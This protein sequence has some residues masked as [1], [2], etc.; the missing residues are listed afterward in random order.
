MN[1]CIH[2]MLY[3]SPAQCI[4]PTTVLSLVHFLMSDTVSPL[5]NSYSMVTVV[6]VPVVHLLKAHTL[7]MMPAFSILIQTSVA[8]CTA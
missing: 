1:A 7:P 4:T 6:R 8:E 5:S 2:I 3:T